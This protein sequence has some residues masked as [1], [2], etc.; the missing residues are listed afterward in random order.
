MRDVYLVIS[1]T[2]AIPD[3]VHD[4]IIVSSSPSSTDSEAEAVKHDGIT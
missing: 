3:V 1:A 4:G 2:H